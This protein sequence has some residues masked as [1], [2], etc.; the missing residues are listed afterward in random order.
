MFSRH[1][2][3][4]A[5]I[6]LV[7]SSLAFGQDWDALKSAKGWCRF[8][9]IGAATFYDPASKHLI[10]WMR[11]A[12]VMG[13]IDTTAAEITP[14]RWVTDD[15]RI[16]VMSGNL[17]KLLN[18][19]GQVQKSIDLPAEI[20]DVDFLP[21]DGLI[22]TYRTV[23]PFVERREFKT[24]KVAWTWGDKP[25]KDRLSSRMLHRLLR[26]ESG[27][28]LIVSDGEFSATTLDGKQGNP[29]GQVIYA[30]NEKMPPRIALGLKHRGALIWGWGSDVAYNAVA[31]ST[32]PGLGLQGL[33]LARMDG[34]ASTVEFLPT[35]LSEDHVLVGV[36]E[37]QAIFIAPNGGLVFV[38][39]K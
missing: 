19:A 13:R 7:L 10:T 27:N 11:D 31:A 35:N 23:T 24:G 34:S 22:L 33:V 32:L 4:A 30:Y 18:K 37:Q 38:P 9:P 6:S 28:I 20:A 36:Q 15:E 8:D 16:W 26:N 5:A 29:L 21:P 3:T 12:G 17:A 25:K 39:V 1:G 2:F 14:E